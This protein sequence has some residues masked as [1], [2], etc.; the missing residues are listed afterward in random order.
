MPA[1]FSRTLRPLRLP[2][3][4]LVILLG[5][6]ALGAQQQ[7]APAP[8]APNPQEGRPTGAPRD[9]SS[10]TH[11]RGQSIITIYNGWHPNTDGTFDLWFGYLSDNWNEE[12]DVPV[13][14]NNNIS[15][16]YG[17]DAGQPTHFF[18]RNNRF[19]FKIT[20]PKDFGKNEIVW[21]LTTA[22]RTYR[23]FATLDPSYVR[24]DFGRS[25]EYWGEPPPEGNDPPEMTLQGEKTRRLKV[26]DYSEIVYTVKDDGKST[27]GFNG[28]GGAAGAGG[29]GA[30]GA[31][32]GPPNPRAAARAAAAARNRR[33]SVCGDQGGNNFFCG[34]PNEGAG[35]LSSVK[36][37]RSSCYLYRGDPEIRI[38]SHDF[39]QASLVHF[40]PPQERVYE[41][42]RG[43]SPWAA[44]Y[45]LPPLPKDNTWHVF[46]SFGRPGTFV[47]RCQAHDG[48]LNTVEDITF[49]VVE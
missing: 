15:A 1:T 11:S 9:D 46:T 45:T 29:A 36:G 35:A 16:P 28:G 18:P 24:D 34:E 14:V 8:A 25:R 30:A 32:G 40:D 12:V 47:V 42:H 39:G 21:T 27:R 49:E 6:A 44:G 43:G 37:L 31:A 20:V 38:A 33:P 41:D 22:G 23:A 2:I 7:P 17:P 10:L 48:L 13:G 26:G 5:A 4:A 19:Q 3:T